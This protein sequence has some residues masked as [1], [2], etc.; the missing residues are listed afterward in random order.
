MKTGITTSEARKG[1]TCSDLFSI[2]DDEYRGEDGTTLKRE[3]G[4]TPNDNPL[5]GRWV[6]RAP[7]G[8]WID[9]NQY[10]HDIACHYDLNLL[11]NDQADTSK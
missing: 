8:E 11:E 1:L 7:D 10:R 9:F 5:N 4:E 3:Y 2:S 6:L